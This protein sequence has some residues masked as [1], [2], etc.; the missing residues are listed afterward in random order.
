[1]GYWVYH[2]GP[3][4]GGGG[5][6]VC[7]CLLCIAVCLLVHSLSG[8][9]VYALAALFIALIAVLNAKNHIV[10][11]AATEAMDFVSTLAFVLKFNGDI[12]FGFFAAL[13]AAGVLYAVF[14]S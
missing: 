1:M 12:Y 14:E 9:W 5:K 2:E 11:L 3:Y 13:I 6:W 10:C 7:G 4:Y 8:S